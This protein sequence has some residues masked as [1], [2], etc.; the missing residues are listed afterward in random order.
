[1]E[2]ICGRK[3]ELIESDMDNPYIRTACYACECGVEKYLTWY[4]GME[5]PEIEVLKNNKKQ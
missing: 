5:E 4:G 1:M 2:C 3:M